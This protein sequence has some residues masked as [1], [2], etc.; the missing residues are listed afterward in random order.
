MI[1]QTS[2]TALLNLLTSVNESDNRNIA[3]FTGAMDFEAN[4]DVKMPQLNQ[5]LGFLLVVNDPKEVTIIHHPHNFGGTL[6][7]PTRLQPLPPPPPTGSSTSKAS[8]VSSLPL[9]FAMRSSRRTHPPLSSSFS[10]AELLMRNMSRFQ[11]RRHQCTPRNFLPLVPWCPSGPSCRNLFLC[12]SG[13]WQNFRMERTP[14]PR[15]YPSKPFH[16]I[17]RPCIRGKHRQH[18]S[19][20]CGWDVLL[21]QGG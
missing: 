18:S 15:L 5:P 12:C 21:L 14:P 8:P 2:W 6:L 13:Q 3:G 7:H 17:C 4:L 1:L 11:Q 9:S 10:Q 16:S 20:R 19:Y